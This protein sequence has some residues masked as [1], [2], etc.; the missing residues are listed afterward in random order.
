VNRGRGGQPRRPPISCKLP[1][2]S[3][4]DIIDEKVR[5]AASSRRYDFCLIL[6]WLYTVALTC[7]AFAFV[8]TSLH[9]L[10]AASFRNADG[11]NLWAFLGFSL[12]AVTP[13]KI[14][15]IAPASAV[16]TLAY[17]IEAASSLIILVILVFIVL[18]AAREAF[19]Q[20]V[21]AFGKELKLTADVIDARIS[22]VYSMTLR[23]LEFFLLKDQAGVVNYLRRARGLAELELPPPAESPAP[24]GNWRQ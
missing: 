9:R 6:G 19:K 10:D 5:T 1:L 23:E 4:A 22:R 21:E 11:A 17:Y 20:D 13:A 12:G 15:S 3:I 2:G 14:S 7:L 18:T 16:A 24:G 8:F